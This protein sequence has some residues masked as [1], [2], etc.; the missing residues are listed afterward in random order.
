MRYILDDFVELSTNNDLQRVELQ[1]IDNCK[2]L[3][4]GYLCDIPNMYRSW[5]V[6]SWYTGNSTEY[7]P[8]SFE[9]RITFCIYES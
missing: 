8:D 5:R 3:F 1:H 2:T 4:E 6:G 9:S 7:D